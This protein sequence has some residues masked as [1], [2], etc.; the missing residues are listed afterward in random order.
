M[1]SGNRISR[2]VDSTVES[3]ART[4][5]GNSRN[6]ASAVT[7]IRQ[8]LLFIGLPGPAQEQAELLLL[9]V[10]LDDES[11]RNYS[12]RLALERRRKHRVIRIILR[13]TGNCW[14]LVD[15]DQAQHAG[16]IGAGH[17][18]AHLAHL[19]KLKRRIGV[20]VHRHREHYQEVPNRRDPHMVSVRRVKRVSERV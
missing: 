3:E 10:T 14:S 19:F 18:G 11:D 12:T 7:L 9:G 15:L 2:L 17:L 4:S 13:H 6:N 1:P 5:T 8:S 16:M 20:R